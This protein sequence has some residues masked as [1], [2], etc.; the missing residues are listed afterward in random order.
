MEVGKMPAQGKQLVKG[1]LLHGLPL[2]HNHN[3]IRMTNGAEAVRDNDHRAVTAENIESLLHQT[4]R[5]RVQRRGSLI[6][7]HHPTPRQ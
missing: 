3:P 6:Q 7:D 2:I 1:P 5:L 4:L